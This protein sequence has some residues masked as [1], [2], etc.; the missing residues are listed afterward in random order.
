VIDPADEGG[1]APC[2]AHLGLDGD[3]CDTVEDI[4]EDD[5]TTPTAPSTGG[6]SSPG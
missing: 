2:F 6:I 3:A 4:D 5:D 1:E